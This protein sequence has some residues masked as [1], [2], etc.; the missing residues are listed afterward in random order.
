MFAIYGDG[1]VVCATVI[2][3]STRIYDGGCVR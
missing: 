3:V 1:Q 2:V